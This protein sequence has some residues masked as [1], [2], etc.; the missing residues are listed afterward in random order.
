MR[1]T[2]RGFARRGASMELIMKRATWILIS[3][4][5]LV[6]AAPAFAQQPIYP[7]NGEG[8]AHPAQPQ[9]E[10]APQP[11]P[12]SQPPYDTQV[13]APQPQV[14]QPYGD[15]DDDDDGYDVTYDISTSAD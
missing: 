7:P 12:Q 3:S 11:Q 8:D 1:V 15:D 5:G 4:I 2:L 10:P 6:A 13:Q 14:Q 9:A